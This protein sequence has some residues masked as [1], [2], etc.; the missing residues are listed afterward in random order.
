[1]KLMMMMKLFYAGFGAET[2]ITVGFGGQSKPNEIDEYVSGSAK[3]S[4]VS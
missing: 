3:T 2:G 4:D 1:M